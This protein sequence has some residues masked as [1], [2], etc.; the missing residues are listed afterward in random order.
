M[1]NADGTNPQQLT[2]NPH[3]NSRKGWRSNSSR[4]SDTYDLRWSPD[5]TRILFASDRDGDYEIYV[6]KAD[7]TNLTQL[8]NNSYDDH[9][10]LWT[11]Q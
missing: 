4:S 5:S 11:T 6:A 1:V 9:Y 3:Q 2:H 10:P 7:G 8:T